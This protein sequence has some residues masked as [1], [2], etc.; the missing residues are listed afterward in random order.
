MSVPSKIFSLS[1]HKSGTTSLH[2]FF[3]ANGL[4]SL[5]YP[6]KF[7]G[8]NYAHAIADVVDDPRMVVE[9]LT[10]VIDAYDAHCDAPWGGLAPELMNLFPSARF[11]LVT[12]DPEQW[13]ES[14]AKHWRLDLC[15]RY[16]SA[17]EYVQYRRYMKAERNRLY[18]RAD[19][20][21]FISAIR[22]QVVHVKDVVPACRLVTVDLSDPDKARKLSDFLGFSGSVAFQH[23][24]P[25]SANKPLKRFRETIRRRFFGSDLTGGR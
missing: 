5:H 11:V 24:M 19:K 16:L 8:V 4:R 2:Q 18:T 21:M 7:G 13:W 3:Q 12:R 25:S 15:G 23:M 9:R 22:Q 10:P 6:K 17:F 14:L 20:D 1:L